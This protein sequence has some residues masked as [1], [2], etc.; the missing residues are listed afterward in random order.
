MFA[1]GKSKHFPE[2]RRCCECY[3]GFPTPCACG[4]L[5]HAQYIDTTWDKHI[6]IDFACDKCGADYKYPE[7]EKIKRKGPKRGQSHLLSGR[8]SNRPR[9]KPKIE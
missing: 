7:P 8:T 9:H 2:D 1:I 6:L 5:I 3:I 4:G